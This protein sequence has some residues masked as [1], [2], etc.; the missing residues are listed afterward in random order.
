[1]NCSAQA[2]LLAL[3]LAVSFAL[4]DASLPGNPLQGVHLADSFRLHH[5]CHFDGKARSFLCGGAFGG[6]QSKHQNDLSANARSRRELGSQLADRAPHKLLMKLCKF[7]CDDY[8]L[9]RTKD[10][11]EICEGVQNAVWGFVKDMCHVASNEF[12][13]CRLSLASFGRQKA[14]EDKLIGWKSTRN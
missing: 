6:G 8:M 7:A 11:F 14:V 5:C 12:F 2:I 9:R 1:V 13:E 3:Q 4:A 10:R